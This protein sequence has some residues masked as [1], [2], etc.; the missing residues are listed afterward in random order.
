MQNLTDTE[1]DAVSGG[2]FAV[3][4]LIWEIANVSNIDAFAQGVVDRFLHERYPAYW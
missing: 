3:A 4:L 1:I 2:M